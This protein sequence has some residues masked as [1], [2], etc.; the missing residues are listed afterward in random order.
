M[1]V[2]AVTILAAGAY[3]MRYEVLGRGGDMYIAYPIGLAIQLFFGL[4]VFW[5]AA[6]AIGAAGRMRIPAI[7]VRLLAVFTLYDAGRAMM[8]DQPVG[9]VA[10][11]AAV[12]LAAMF[13]LFAGAYRAAHII[14]IAAVLFLLKTIGSTMIIDTWFTWFSPTTS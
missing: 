11:L 13:G 4:V 10:I 2:A 1:V 7:G 3:A 14:F 6:G 12:H 5:A 9:A 8:F